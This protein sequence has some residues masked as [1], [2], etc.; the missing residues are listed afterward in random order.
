MALSP[1]DACPGHNRLLAALPQAHADALLMMAYNEQS[2]HKGQHCFNSL[3]PRWFC[4]CFC[5]EFSGLQNPGA[6][7]HSDNIAE[8]GTWRYRSISS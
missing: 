2:Y 6:G 8:N 5:E 7:R 3:F 1:Q 4:S